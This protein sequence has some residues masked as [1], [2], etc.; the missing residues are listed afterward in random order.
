MGAISG[1][2]G[3]EIV[4]DFLETENSA[5]SRPASL[6]SDHDARNE[7]SQWAGTA[8]HFGRNTQIARIA[9]IYPRSGSI[10]LLRRRR[11]RDGCEI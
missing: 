8:D 5:A 6:R 3:V 10:L 4:A 1:I 7:R 2:I 11:D 9:A